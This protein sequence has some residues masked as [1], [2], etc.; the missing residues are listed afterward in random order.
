MV[1]NPSALRCRGPRKSQIDAGI[2]KRKVEAGSAFT[3][4][5]AKQ[6]WTKI[7]EHLENA[8]L[9]FRVKMLKIHEVLT[10]S[11]A[12]Y[13]LRISGTSTQKCCFGSDDFFFNEG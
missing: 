3:A 9:G 11:G 5:E 12:G 6:D 10:C 1:E 13:S 8:G 2:C 4:M 7:D